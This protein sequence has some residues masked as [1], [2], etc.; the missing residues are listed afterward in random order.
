[1]KQY[2]YDIIVRLNST[3][4]FSIENIKYDKMQE[5]FIKYLGVGYNVTVVEV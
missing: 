1:M 5:L 4:V 3:I 2:K